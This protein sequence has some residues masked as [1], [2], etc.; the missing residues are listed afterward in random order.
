MTIAASLVL[1]SLAVPATTAFL[2]PP[3]FSA[4]AAAV[5]VSSSRL[6]AVASRSHLPRHAAHAHAPSVV[7]RPPPGVSASND[8]DIILDDESDA[9]IAITTM[10]RRSFLL[11]TGGAL[12]ALSSTTRPT[13]ARA[14]ATAAETA[15]TYAPYVDAEYGFR[16]L[17][18]S[19]WERS[20]QTLSGRRRAIF[21]TDPYSRT[22]VGGGGDI[23]T[24]CIVAYTPVRDDFTSQ[25][26]FGSVDEVGQS[27]I[28]PKEL[29]GG[30][31]STST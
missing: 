13:V 19:S 15:T 29:A 30:D 25:S 27:T 28:L 24:L 12:A 21:Y 16:V 2:A 22:A 1:L 3:P 8:D 7:R 14:A 31:G 23:E 4:A 9:V 6:N 17:L 5:V 20:E 11:R 18:P 10:A 26:S